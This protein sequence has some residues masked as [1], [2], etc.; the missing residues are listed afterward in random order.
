MTNLSPKLQT[1][2][3]TQKDRLLASLTTILSCQRFSSDMGF[4]FFSALH[5]LC[6]IATISSL[7]VSM[8]FMKRTEIDP[9]L[10]CYRKGLAYSHE[11]L[12]KTVDMACE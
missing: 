2:Q 7:R 6:S 9:N 11:V 4:V 10:K 5:G 8:S 1:Y 12:R 3:D